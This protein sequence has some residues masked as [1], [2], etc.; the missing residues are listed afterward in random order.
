MG[1]ARLTLSCNTNEVFVSSNLESGIK[2]P[3][4]HR[5]L[6]AAESTCF[7]PVKLNAALKL[8]RGMLPDRLALLL[9][10]STICNHNE[11]HKD[12]IFKFNHKLHLRRN[13]QAFYSLITSFI[14]A[15][16]CKAEPLASYLISTR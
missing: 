3:S 9:K 1:T 8:P 11:C 12:N 16:G 5:V 2:N 4:I 7:D 6:V 15:G 10:Y 13:N 14:L